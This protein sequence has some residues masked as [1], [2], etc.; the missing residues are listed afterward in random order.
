MAQG[1]DGKQ[2]SGTEVM[3]HQEGVGRQMRQWQ[4][5]Y[6]ALRGGGREGNQSE[7]MRLRSKREGIQMAHGWWNSVME[8]RGQGN[9]RTMTVGMWLWSIEK[10]VETGTRQWECGYAASGR[11]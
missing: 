6:G 9:D 1:S 3:V 8:H 5:G 10:G 11:L 2:G 7:V 4:C